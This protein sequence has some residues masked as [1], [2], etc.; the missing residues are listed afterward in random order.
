VLRAADHG[1]PVVTAVSGFSSPLI[2]R[3]EE[4]PNIT[5]QVHTQVVALEGA[6]RLERVGWRSGAD[7]D[8]EMHDIGHV[9]LMT[10]AVPNTDWLRGCVCLDDRGF[11]RTGFDHQDGV[12]RAGHGQLEE[13]ATR[14]LTGDR[15]RVVTAAP[16]PA[17]GEKVPIKDALGDG[18]LR[19][20]REPAAEVSVGVAILKPAREHDSERGPR[21]DAELPGT[22]DRRREP[23][24]GDRDAHAALD[25]ERQLD[26]GRARLP[27]C[28]CGHRTILVRAGACANP[29][30]P[31]SPQ[32]GS[33]RIA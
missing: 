20:G 21:H 9:F 17:V 30:G 33:A 24:T 13:C 12:A 31:S 16:R 14:A 11:V 28:E 4:N 19:K 23:P 10:G 5:L 26:T 1:K 15:H 27:L 32:T 7:G 3:I 8:V 18:L 6:D 25:Q 22:G 2:R 29:A